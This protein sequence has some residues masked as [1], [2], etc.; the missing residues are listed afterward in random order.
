M[1]GCFP[2]L[3]GEMVKRGEGSGSIISVVGAME[4]CDGQQL[5]LKAADGVS[6]TYNIQADLVFEVVSHVTLLYWMLRFFLA[7]ICIPIFAD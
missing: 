1:D 5:V 3:N 4:S 7:Y 2:R 6:L